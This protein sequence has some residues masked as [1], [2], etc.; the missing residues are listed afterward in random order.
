MSYIRQDINI[1][2]TLRNL[3]LKAGYTQEELATKMQ[4]YGCHTTRSIYAQIENGIH[5][6]RVSELD[7]LRKIYNTTADYILFESGLNLPSV[8]KTD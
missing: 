5:G 7:A 6:V 2:P 3:R 8:D 1:G 4:L